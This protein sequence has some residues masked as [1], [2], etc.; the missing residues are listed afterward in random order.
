LVGVTFTDGLY[1]HIMPSALVLLLYAL[2]V[3]RL[4]TLITTD[5]ISRPTRRHLVAR[6][7][8]YKR[9]HRWIVYALG[10]AE[11]GTANGCPWCVSVWVAAATAPLIWVAHQ[12]PYVL[13]P[14][15][16]LAASQVTGMIFKI[17]RQ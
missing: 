15:L 14:T 1:D 4:T 7:D 11:D 12:S 9:L 8:P 16:A 2:A 3:A 6:F 5:E 10:D 17:G 13:V